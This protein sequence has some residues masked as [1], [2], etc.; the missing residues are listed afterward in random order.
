MFQP[1]SYTE[2]LTFFQKFKSLD[3]WLILCVLILGAIGTISMYSSEGGDFL[4]Y[5]KSH[6]IRFT[7]FFCNDVVFVIC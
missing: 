3:F 5:T 1:G 7:V 2:Q 6:I 4:Y